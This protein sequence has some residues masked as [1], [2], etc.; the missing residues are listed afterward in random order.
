MSQ[1]KLAA[2]RELITEKHYA[3]ARAVLETIP[4]D[5]TAGRWKV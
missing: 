4:G 5:E 2:A 1:A 3:A